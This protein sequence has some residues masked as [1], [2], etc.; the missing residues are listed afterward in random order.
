MNWDSTKRK[1]YRNKNKSYKYAVLKVKLH[2]LR[3]NTLSN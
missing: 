3:N 2:T 1:M